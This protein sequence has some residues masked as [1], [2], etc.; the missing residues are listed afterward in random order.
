MKFDPEIVAHAQAF[1]NAL[2]SGSRAHV[3]PMPFGLWQQFMTTIHLLMSA[4]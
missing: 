3:P 1:V 2:A 4:H